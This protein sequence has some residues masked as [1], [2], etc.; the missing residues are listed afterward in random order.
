GFRVHGPI[1]RPDYFDE[2]IVFQGA[3][4]FR[5]VGRG[6]LYGLS[7]RGLAINTARPGGEE[8]PLFRAFWIEKPAQGA[9]SIVIHALLDSV[10]T[11][12]AYRFVVEPGEATT[13]DVEA[14]LYPRRALTHVGLGPLTSM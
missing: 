2:Y 3:S 13:V 14:T 7:A 12:G 1:N 5:A 10:S 4:Y 9:R 6:Q 8:F 11:T